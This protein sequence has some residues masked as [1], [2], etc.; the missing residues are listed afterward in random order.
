MGAFG[1]WEELGGDLGERRFKYDPHSAGH[2][3]LR[4]MLL[5]VPK[6]MTLHREPR[7]RL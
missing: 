4:A 2:S 3:E 1:G 7:L 5:P 6:V